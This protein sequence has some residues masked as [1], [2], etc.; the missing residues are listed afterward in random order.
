[1]LTA[2]RL[3]LVSWRAAAELL[4]RAAVPGPVRKRRTRLTDRHSEAEPLERRFLLAGGLF[5]PQQ[6]YGVGQSPF[7]VA[8][9]DVNGDGK[10]DVITANASSGTVSVLIGN[11]NGTFQAQRTFATSFVGEGNPE[12]M[13]VAVADVN[14]DGKP[15]LVVAN[16]SFNEVVVL[17][18]NGDGTFQAPQSFPVGASPQFVAVADVNGDGKPDIVASSLESDMVNVLLGNGDGRFQSQQSF[19]VG[20]SPNAV[21]IADVTGDGKPDLIVANY[22]DGT[23]GLLAGNGNGTFQSQQTFATGG[24]FDRFVAVADVNGDGKPDLLF[25]DSSPAQVGVMLGNGNGT[26]QSPQTFAVTNPPSSLAVADVNGDGRPDLIV[27]KE[28]GSAISVLLGNGN[29]TFQAEQTFG[30]GASPWS[31]AA[32]DL[33]AD[34]KPDIVTANVADGTA[35]V[36]LATPD[37][38][39]PV[40]SITSAPSITTAGGTTQTIT[41][42]YTDPDSNVVRSSISTAELSV[43][44]PGGP[45]AVR[46]VSVSPNSNAPTLTATYT[47]AAPGGSWTAADNGTYTVTAQG[48]Q[49]SDPSGN[50]AAAASGSFAVNIAANDTTPPAASITSAPNITTAGGSNQTIT[51]TYSDPDSNVV[52]S[53][54]GP[55]NLSVTGP[56]GPLSVTGVSISPGSDAPTLTATY[57]VAAPGGAWSPADNGTYT[58]A[59]QGGQVSDPAGN[60]AAAV[61][62]T[63]GVSIGVADATPPVASITS[64]PDV[65]APGGTS[66]TISVT[67]S[68]PDSNV[69]GSTI[70]P[71]NVTITGPGGPLTVTSV[72]ISPASAAP[73]LTA[74]YTVTAPGGQWTA[75]DNGTYTITVQGGQVADPSG[76][77]A[78]AVTGSFKVN[79]AIS[80]TPPPI[81]TTFGNNGTVQLP[82]IAEEQATEPDGTIV[83]PGHMGDPSANAEQAVCEVLNV[84]GTPNTSFNGTGMVTTPAGTNAAFFATLP[85]SD[86][87]VI[88]VG[89]IGSSAFVAKALANGT[90]D[91]TFGTGGVMTLPALGTGAVLYAVAAGQGGTVYVGGI[92]GGGLPVVARLIASGALDP[93]FG[94]GGFSTIITGASGSAVGALA[95][96]ADGK[97]VAAGP[98]GGGVDVVRLNTDGSLD[99]AYGT[100]GIA[101]A[102]GLGVTQQPNNAPDVTEGLALQADGKILVA[103]TTSKADFGLVRL[104]ADGSPDSSFGTGGLVTTDFGGTDDVDTVLV[105]P[106]SGQIVATGTTDAGGGTLQ[107]AVAAYRPDGTLDPS[108]GNGAGMVTLPTNVAPLSRAFYLG[109]FAPLRASAAFQPAAAGSAA[110]RLVVGSAG[111]PQNTSALQRLLLPAGITDNSLLRPTVS[112]RLPTAT[113][114]SGRKGPAVTQSVRLTNSG[115]T[116]MTGPISISLLLS[117]SQAGSASDPVLTTIKRRINL[118]P[119]KSAA[120]PVTARAVPAAAT[121]GTKFVVAVVTDPGSMTGV[122][123]SS[124]TIQVQLPVVDLSGAFVKVPTSAKAGG[125][126]TV[127]ISVT[128]NGNVPV[129]ASLPIQLLTSTSA[130]G[131]NPTN[132]VTLTRHVATPAGKTIRLSLQVTLPSAAGTAAFLVAVLDPTNT[133]GDNNLANNTFVSATAIS[134]T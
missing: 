80:S 4:D 37:T 92:A 128:Q 1:M 54:I 106:A 16:S 132:L 44:G 81:D 47:V 107:V 58:V 72:S 7:S 134:L 25:T 45:L 125:R 2:Q 126:A 5:Q 30:T 43:T 105:D 39:P 35:S 86:G 96:Q 102:A 6:S 29:G 113:L 124:N 115:T 76:N 12:P 78:A 84:D 127:T 131:S 94:N 57:S 50:L 120:F 21:A 41:V 99:N 83:V 49:V 55:Q 109:S 110:K 122:G 119:G 3:R 117:D 64:A 33:N 88:C 95:V 121:A 24:S 38:T 77:K 68:D 75:A 27:G 98:A 66:E 100:N 85:L 14:G 70:G 103:N 15:D 67:F 90:L 18:G 63:F 91:P 129:N 118:K 112:G 133:L 46:N 13:S 93:T 23:I 22:I 73:T 61:S 51:V 82:F 130:D 123:A 52:R 40:A 53:S 10:P 59:V 101:T 17:L 79:I 48:G 114:V 89:Q 87:S 11:G 9:A 19:F 97:I 34:G 26:F 28:D 8:V 111:G 74:T 108:F 42:T 116:A 20:S 31:V 69:L 56:G 65:T 60:T 71:G 32:A 62:G 104:N 36:L